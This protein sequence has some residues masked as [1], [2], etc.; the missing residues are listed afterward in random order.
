MM[1]SLTLLLRPDLGRRAYRLRCRF[2]VNAF[3]DKDMLEKAKFKAAEMFVRDMA[4]QGWAYLDKHG[5]KMTGPFVPMNIVSLPKRHQQARWHT[6]SREMLAAVRDGYRGRDVPDQGYVTT[7]AP[8]QGADAWDFEL[9]GVFVHKT[10]LTESPD[11]H[12]EKEVLK[13]R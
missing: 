3:P 5:F 13:Q 10:I 2:T 1:N 7:V 12:E 6:P 11:P 4:K 8:I 9:A